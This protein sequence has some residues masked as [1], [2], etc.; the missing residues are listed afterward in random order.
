MDTKVKHAGYLPSDSEGMKRKPDLNW[1]NKSYQQWADA[2]LKH[3]HPP[4]DLPKVQ[5]RVG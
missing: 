1:H 4:Y 5:L 2:A 3:L